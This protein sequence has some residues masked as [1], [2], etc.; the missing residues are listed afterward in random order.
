MRKC[1]TLIKKKINFIQIPQRSPKINKINSP[2]KATVVTQH[3]KPPR[4][5]PTLFFFTTP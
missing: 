5:A 4:D 1:H 2:A 3:K